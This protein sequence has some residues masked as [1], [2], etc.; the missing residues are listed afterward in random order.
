MSAIDTIA[1]RARAEAARQARAEGRRATVDVA[2]NASEYSLA[3]SLDPDTVLAM[4]DYIQELE[5]KVKP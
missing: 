4:L 2:M 5:R 1:L 3:V